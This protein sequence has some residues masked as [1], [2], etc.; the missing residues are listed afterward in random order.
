MKKLL[1]ALA[2]IAAV[3]AVAGE[4]ALLNSSG[5]VVQ[6]IVADGAAIMDRD[7]GPWVKASPKK[8]GIGWKYDGSKFSA[9]GSTFTVVSSSGTP[10]IAPAP[11]KK[12][13]GVKKSN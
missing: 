2:I 8:V 3:P 7:D 4:W 13:S 10:Q 1:L 6:V 11:P 12:K 9:P 5:T